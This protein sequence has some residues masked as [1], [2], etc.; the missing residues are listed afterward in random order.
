M[1]ALPRQIASGE[2]DT[3]NDFLRDAVWSQAS[4]LSGDEIL[5]RATG[6][7]LDARHF[8]AHLRKRYLET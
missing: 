1:P 5:Q 7:S 6:E 8:E 3:L 4:M 2:F